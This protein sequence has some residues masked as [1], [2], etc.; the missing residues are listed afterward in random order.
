MFWLIGINDI[1]SVLF[2]SYL[3][4]VLPVA[5][6]LALRLSMVVKA[7]SLVWEDGSIFLTGA[8][9]GSL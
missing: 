2:R 6:I 1:R 8:L 4:T 9:S 3:L 5:G 7:S